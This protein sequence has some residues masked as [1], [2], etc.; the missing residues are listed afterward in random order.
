MKSEFK[1]HS[2][3]KSDNGHLYITILVDEDSKFKVEGNNIHTEVELDC[4][5]ATCGGT[6]MV[7]T[8]HGMKE[9]R[10]EGG[11]QSGS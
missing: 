4:I 6:I 8:V 9:V 10:I 1:G 7:E 3:Y 11:T 5:T 2:G